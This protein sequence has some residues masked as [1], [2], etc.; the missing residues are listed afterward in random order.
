M[1]PK[2]TLD[3]SINQIIQWFISSF[4]QKHPEAGHSPSVWSAEANGRHDT[5]YT[6]RHGRHRVTRA[7]QPTAVQF[8]ALHVPKGHTYSTYTHTSVR[9]YIPRG[10]HPSSSNSSLP[11]TTPTPSPITALS[12]RPSLIPPLARLSASTTT[13]PSPPT[14]VAAHTDPLLLFQTRHLTGSAELPTLDSASSGFTPT[15][16]MSAPP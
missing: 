1:L 6:T 11:L 15:L 4:P 2:R 16:L 12:A 10:K 9:H 3:K 5:T 13:D 14:S 7:P 8:K